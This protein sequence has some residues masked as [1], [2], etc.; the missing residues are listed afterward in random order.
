MRNQRFLQGV[1]LLV[2]TVSI[3]ACNA[4]SLPRLA[5]SAPGLGTPVANEKWEVT[6]TNPRVEKRLQ[7]SGTTTYTPN[8]GYTFLL[9]DAAFRNLDP[10]Q[11]T[12]ISGSTLTLIDSAGEVFENTG[13]SFGITYSLGS[14]VTYSNDQGDTLK[15]TLVFSVNEANIGQEYKFQFLDLPQIPFTVKPK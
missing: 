9:V 8:S 1:V 10:S 15:L 2:L 13:S 12:F 6:I 7:G 3:L 11:E 4:V 5:A 14:L